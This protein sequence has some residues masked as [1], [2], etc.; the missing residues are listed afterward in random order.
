MKTKFAILSLVVFLPSNLAGCGKSQAE[1]TEEKYREVGEQM[2]K[3]AKEGKYTKR[4]PKPLS[5]EDFHKRTPQK[6]KPSES[7]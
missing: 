3:D 7:K 6:D 4:A 2:I 1:V 5:P